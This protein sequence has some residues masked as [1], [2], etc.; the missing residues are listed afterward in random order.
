MDGIMDGRQPLRKS[1]APRQVRRAA[2]VVADEK[3]ADPP[4]R[5]AHG[6]RD[7]GRIG[8]GNHRDTERAAADQPP[9]A[10]PISPP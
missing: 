5:L 3:A 1:D 4:D 7:R 2:V 6:Q 9:S 8:E 10:P